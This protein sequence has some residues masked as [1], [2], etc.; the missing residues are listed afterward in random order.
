[1]NLSMQNEQKNG[2]DIPRPNLGESIPCPPPI[3]HPPAAPMDPPV[4]KPPTMDRPCF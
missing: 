4:S 2:G 1:M 3:T